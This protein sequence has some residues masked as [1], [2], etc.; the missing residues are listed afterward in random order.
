MFDVGR[1]ELYAICSINHY[2]YIHDQNRL[3]YHY[4]IQNII[5]S[6]T[7]RCNPQ[8]ALH[9][10]MEVKRSV[11][12]VVYLHFKDNKEKKPVCL[13]LMYRYA[14]Q[15]L[16]AKSHQKSPL[17]TKNENSTTQHN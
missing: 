6:R 14:P 1:Q 10:T 9:L 15:G 3:G 17:Y 12:Y 8:A 4:C 7:K 11:L 16:A 2:F 13:S 5:K